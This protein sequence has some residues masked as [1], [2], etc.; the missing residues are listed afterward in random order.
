MIGFMRVTILVLVIGALAA[1]SPAAEQAGGPTLYTND[2]Q[3]ANVGSVPE[4][5]MVMEGAFAVREEN[6]NK[7]LELPGSPLE[8]FGV[9]FGPNEADG[10]AVSARIHG[11]SKGRRAP[12][13]GVGLN[14]VSGYKLQMAPAKRSLELYRGDELL[15]TV[16]AAWES[17]SWTV[18]RLGL[19]KSGNA[20]WKITGEAWKEGAQQKDVATVTHQEKPPPIAGKASIWGAPY[21]GTPIRFDDMALS[22]Q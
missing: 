8:T 15:A 16:P 4:D 7:F 21:A 6:G 2:F 17:G 13:F 1:C 11:T 3:K 12:T 5:L 9:L 22:N 14:G 10:V 20:E 19:I 18:L